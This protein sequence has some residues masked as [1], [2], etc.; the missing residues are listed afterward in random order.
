MA[1][2]NRLQSLGASLQKRYGGVPTNRGPQRVNAAYTPKPQP[3]LAP[4]PSPTNP[5]GSIGMSAPKPNPASG[6]NMINPFEQAQQY[7]QQAAGVFGQMTGYQAP[8]YQA[9]TLGAA[10][11]LGQVSVGQLPTMAGANVGQYMNPY[12]EQVIE[13]GQQ[14]IA[15]QQQQALNVLGAQAPRGAFG[16][17]RYGLAEAQTAAEYGR[18]ALDFG[19]QQRQQAFQQAQAQAQFDIQNQIARQQ[20]EVAAERARQQYNVGAQTQRQL[21]QL[22]QQNLA[23]QEAYDRSLRQMGIRQQGAQALSG[24]GE[25]AFSRGQYGIQQQQMAAQQ[26]MQMQQQ[27]LDA[28][29]AQTLANLGYPQQSLTFGTNVLGGLPR[30]SVTESGRMGVFDAINL[31]AG[32]PIG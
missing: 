7:Q 2:R 17:D 11:Q 20:Q 30:A 18:Q 10:P 25:E 24:L 28:A 14:D 6:A 5:S 21:E 12:T 19:A 32:L 26:Q 31:V 16:G 22:S 1:I 4:R 29:R 13:R 8:Q 23:Q 9:P 3:V 15:R 27:L